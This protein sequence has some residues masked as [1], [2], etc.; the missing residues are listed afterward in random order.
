MVS[1]CAHLVPFRWP[2]HICLPPIL[3]VPVTVASEASSILSHDVSNSHSLS[4]L[5]DAT[6]HVNESV[7]CASTTS[8][9]TIALH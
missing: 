6:P 2:S 4:M 3:P 8:D 9:S 5:E 1:F 7:L